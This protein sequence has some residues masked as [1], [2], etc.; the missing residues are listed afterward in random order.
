MND[1]GAATSLAAVTAQRS[2]R[3]LTVE[4]IVGSDYRRLVATRDHH[5]NP[6]NHFSENLATRSSLPVLCVAGN[7]GTGFHPHLTLTSEKVDSASARAHAA[8]PGAA[9]KELRTCHALG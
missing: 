5:M 3:S 4:Q 6:G 8:S 7:E 1:K 2:I 9:S